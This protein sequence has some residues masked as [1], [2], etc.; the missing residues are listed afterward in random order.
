MLSS[1]L[2]YVIIPVDV[3]HIYS[4]LADILSWPRPCLS[5]VVCG[6]ILET[7]RSYCGGGRYLGAR[8]SDARSFDTNLL[9]LNECAL[10]HGAAAVCF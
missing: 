4:L 5:P 9:T 6:V 7:H 3:I 8:K 1:D 10:D 2:A